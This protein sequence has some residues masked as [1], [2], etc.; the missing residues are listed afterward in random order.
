M[1]CHDS[2]P[3]YKE[4]RLKSKQQKTRTHTQISD[5]ILILTFGSSGSQY[6]YCFNINSISHIKTY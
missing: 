2:D 3:L 1:L 5:N 6:F 4:A